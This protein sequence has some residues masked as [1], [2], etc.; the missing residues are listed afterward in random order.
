MR[1]TVLPRGSGDRSSRTRVFPEVLAVGQFA[2]MG[3]GGKEMSRCLAV[4]YCRGY[5]V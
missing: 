1:R 5:H 2:L 4:P 3:S